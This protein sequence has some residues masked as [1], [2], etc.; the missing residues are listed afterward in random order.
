MNVAGDKMTDHR[1]P[2]GGGFGIQIGVSVELRKKGLEIE[3]PEGMHPGLVAVIAGAPITFA[4]G[5]RNGQ[6]GYFLAI[7]KNAKFGFA[8]QNLAAAN[9]RNLAGLVSQAVIFEDFV[10]FKGELGF[11]ASGHVLSRF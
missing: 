2:A 1:A 11:L 3:D 10:G 9:Q 4:E 6:L 5:A 7:A 8:A